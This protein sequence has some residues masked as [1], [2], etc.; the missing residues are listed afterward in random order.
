VSLSTLP[1]QIRAGQLGAWSKA[2]PHAVFRAAV[3]S[4]PGAYRLPARNRAI[5]LTQAINNENIK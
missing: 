4:V 1:E 3:L 2:D 5:V